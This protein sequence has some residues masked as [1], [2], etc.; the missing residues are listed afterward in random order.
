MHRNDRPTCSS[1]PPS[2]LKEEEFMANQHNHP[3]QEEP[4]SYGQTH[5]EVSDIDLNSASV[6]QLADL[7][8]VGP[9]R[10]KTLIGARPFRN[11]G[12]VERLEGFSTGMVDD[13]ESGGAHI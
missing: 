6:E 3:G 10:A 7:P 5:H 13:L 9:E 8:M 12:E 11:W 1:S 4:R 2:D